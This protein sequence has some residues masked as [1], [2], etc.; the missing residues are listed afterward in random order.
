MK[1]KSF[2]ITV[3][4]LVFGCLYT[5]TTKRVLFLGNSYTAVNNLPQLVASVASSAGD[6]VIYD[7]NTPGGYTLQGH[8]SDANSLSKITIGNWDFV[9]LQ[10]QS[11]MPSFPIG[12]VQSSVFPY[13]K[14]LDSLILAANPCT[15]TMFFMTWGRKNGDASN[16]SV[17]PPVCTYEGMDS[18]LHLR[19]MMMTDSNHAVVSA[20]GAVW[21]YLRINYP[22]MDLYQSDGSHPSMEGSYAAACCFYSSLFRKDPN[23][24]TFNSSLSAADAGVIR[25]A[26]KTVIYDSLLKWS[27]GKHDPVAYFSFNSSG[28]NFS[29]TNTSENASQFSWD[30]GDGNTSNGISP[31]HTYAASGTYTVTLQAQE[32]GL[33][34]T[35]SYVINVF[36]AQMEDN[37]LQK[38]LIAFPNP[39]STTIS[40]RTDLP[41]VN[42]IEATDIFGKVYSIK[43]ENHSQLVSADLTELKQGVYFLHL[44]FDDGVKKI[45]IV[46][47]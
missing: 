4:S 40:F 3:L 6:S 17:W 9:V 10:E 16:C 5:Q 13:A 36:T 24:I 45:K 37:S 8:S 14:K 46:K 34:D 29:F 26:V 41:K 15:E 33:S 42:T 18:L 2:F 23:L 19:Y 30:F 22:M 12:Q 7:S 35:F 25:S 38:E 20:V 47:Q 31:G 44:F 28:N 11:Q 21:N 32:C 43:F 1:L 39:V 27:I